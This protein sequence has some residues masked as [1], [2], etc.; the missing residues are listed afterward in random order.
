M[1]LVAGEGKLTATVRQY[2]KGGPSRLAR[3]VW[4]WSSMQQSV[5]EA[6]VK[7]STGRWWVRRPEKDFEKRRPAGGQGTVHPV[8]ELGSQPGQ[9]L[10]G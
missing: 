6:S 5:G 4:V 10:D 8:E 1:A 7:V 9:A 2:H 3:L